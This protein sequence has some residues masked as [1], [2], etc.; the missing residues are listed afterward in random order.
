MPPGRN[1]GTAPS[2][3]R[4]PSPLHRMPVSRRSVA[5]LA[6]A[7]GTFAIRRREARHE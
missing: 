4:G 1:L 5:L 3:R 2:C 7:V 6:A